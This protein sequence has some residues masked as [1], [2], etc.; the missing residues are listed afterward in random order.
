MDRTQESN[1]LC[2]REAVLVFSI[3]YLADWFQRRNS[4]RASQLPVKRLERSTKYQLLNTDFIL[5]LKLKR[6][7]LGFLAH[8]HRSE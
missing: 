6:F 3:W 4:R 8:P 7:L 1:G 5:I 2:G